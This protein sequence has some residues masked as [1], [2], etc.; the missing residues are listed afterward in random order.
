[1]KNLRQLNSFERVNP[2]VDVV[3]VSELKSKLV[4]A[5]LIWVI[6]FT[7]WNSIGRNEVSE[8]CKDNSIAKIFLQDSGWW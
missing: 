5:V 2:L 7:Q 6:N 3:C 4:E 1:M 8:L